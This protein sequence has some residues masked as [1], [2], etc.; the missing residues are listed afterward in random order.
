MSFEVATGWGT[1]FEPVSCNYIMQSLKISVYCRSVSLFDEPFRFSP[2]GII[3]DSSGAVGI[4]EMK[5]PLTRIWLGWNPQKNRLIA[6]E[7]LK[8]APDE[9]PLSYTPQL[10]LGLHLIPF[11]SYAYYVEFI[12]R[13]ANGSGRATAIGVQRMREVRDAPILDSGV[14]GFYHKCGTGNVETAYDFSSTKND[15]LLCHVLAHQRDPSKGDVFTPLYFTE[16]LR[17]AAPAEEKKVPSVDTLSESLAGLK[18]EEKASAAASTTVPDVPKS[19][20]TA[21]FQDPTTAVAS[22]VFKSP[23]ELPPTS[24][25]KPLFGYMFWQLLGAHAVRVDRDE[26][27]ITPEIRQNATFVSTYV[28]SCIPMTNQQRLIALRQLR[29]IAVLAH[30]SQETEIE[31]FID[32][33][34]ASQPS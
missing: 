25:G 16:T 22:P 10:Q 28:R 24:G 15:L 1:L 4:L 33:V 14:I 9:V 19:D 31:T 5:N 11:A 23:Q 6:P 17:A 29:D 21:A 27:F 2:D 30:S 20:L 34:S 26:N 32:K 8:P 12:I 7:L 18:I 3:C 13:R